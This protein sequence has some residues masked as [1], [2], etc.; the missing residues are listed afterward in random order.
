M[1]NS[2]KVILTPGYPPLPSLGQALRGYDGYHICLILNA[3]LSFMQRQITVLIYKTKTIQYILLILS[4]SFLFMT[5]KA[6]VVFFVTLLRVTFGAVIH[7]HAIPGIEFIACDIL[8]PD[9]DAVSS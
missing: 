6:G 4:E 7:L 2:K 1:M 3:L 5:D 8:A 9:I